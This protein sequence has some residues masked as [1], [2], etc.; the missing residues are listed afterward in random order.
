MW[1]LLR[2]FKTN[3]HAYLMTFSNQIIVASNSISNVIDDKNDRNDMF[4]VLRMACVYFSK[5]RSISSYWNIS[6]PFRWLDFRMS[7]HYQ[8]GLINDG[9]KHQCALKPK[10]VFVHAICGDSF[11]LWTKKFLQLR[12]NYVNDSCAIYYVN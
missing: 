2:I 3:T 9:L 6:N 5:C 11:G 4:N 10:F 8:I 1:R 12:L 7:H